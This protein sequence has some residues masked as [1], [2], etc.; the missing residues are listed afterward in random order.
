ERR[1]VALAR[2]EPVDPAML[3]YLNRLSDY[4]FAL[5]IGRMG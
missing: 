3:A 5:A 2:T 4:L 1:M